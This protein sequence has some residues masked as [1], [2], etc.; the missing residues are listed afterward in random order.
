MKLHKLRKVLSVISYPFVITNLCYS[1][2]TPNQGPPNVKKSQHIHVGFSIIMS[3]Y[4]NFR[5]QSIN[6]KRTLIV[7]YG[8]KRFITYQ[9]H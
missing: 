7:T 9:V 3:K 5:V 6:Q 8:A 2:V 4:H 1:V